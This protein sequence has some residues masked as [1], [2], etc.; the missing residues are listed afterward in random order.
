M[1]AAELTPPATSRLRGELQRGW[2][3]AYGAVWA[4]TL[5]SA[6]IV[7]AVGPMKT[8]VRNLLRLHLHASETPV[9]GLRHVVA[10]AGHNLPIAAWPVLL[11]VAG[12]HRSQ[13]GRRLADTV[14]VAAIAAN[15]LPAGAA[16]G[17]YGPALL[18]YVLQL[19]LEW[20]GLA[21]GSTAWLAQRDRT[22]TVREG[23]AILTITA[24]AL[25]CAA[26]IETFA[27]PHQQH[28]ANLRGGRYGRS[29]DTPIEPITEELKHEASGHGRHSRRRQGESRRDS[30]MGWRAP[31]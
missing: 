9:P 4:A 12:A 14:V 29:H 11:G 2:L 24:V 23:L 25:L 26:S 31:R 17:A 16:L 20:A 10:L 1:A 19:P 15:I 21:L 22:L 18:P 7:G 30:G 13:L 8:P 28:A 5:A 27:V 3:A 6:L